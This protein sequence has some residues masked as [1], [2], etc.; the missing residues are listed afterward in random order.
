MWHRVRLGS[1][2]CAFQPNF[3]AFLLWM[4]FS[5][6]IHG[7]YKLHFSAIFSLKMSFT[8]LFTHLKIILL[9]YF[10]V[11]NF[12]FQFSI[13]FKRS[14][15]TSWLNQKFYKKIFSIVLRKLRCDSIFSLLEKSCCTSFMSQLIPLS[16]LMSG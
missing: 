16:H 3:L 1:A 11:F 13:V 9:Q 8:V 5:W 12:S 10:S 7:S 15:I 14:L 2:F 4:V 6:I